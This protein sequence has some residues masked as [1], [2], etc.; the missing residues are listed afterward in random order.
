MIDDPRKT[1]LYSGVVVD[2]ADPRIELRGKLDNCL[3]WARHTEREASEANPFGDYFT[4]ILAKCM[5]A[6]VELVQNA[7]ATDSIEPIAELITPEYMQE[8]RNYACGAFGATP[9]DKMEDLFN[10][11][12]TKLRE[13]E[14]AACQVPRSE[15]IDAIQV[16]LNALSAL[17]AGLMVGGTRN[18]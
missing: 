17:A 11:Q 12:R 2:K 10:I 6:L 4:R 14:L 16:A 5:V 13:A 18:D 7:E 8:V 15:V 3:A 1:E 9:N